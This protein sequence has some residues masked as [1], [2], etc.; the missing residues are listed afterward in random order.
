MQKQMMDTM[1]GKDPH[2]DYNVQ[3]KKMEWLKTY[4][5]TQSQKAVWDEAIQRH[6]KSLL[7]LQNE[8]KFFES[9]QNTALT[10]YDNYVDDVKN[11]K[12]RLISETNKFVLLQMKQNESRKRQEREVRLKER[13]DLGKFLPSESDQHLIKVAKADVATRR[14]LEE[15]HLS[16][17]QLRNDRKVGERLN[18]KTVAQKYEQEDIQ[19][20]NTDTEERLKRKRVAQQMSANVWKQQIEL[21]KMQRS[22]Q[23]LT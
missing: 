8:K 6:R 23:K 17:V 16:A 14:D 3:K 13:Y 4:K 18:E 7:S 10:S 11:S 15:S 20:L 22:L 9:E 2:D 12:Q 5:P 1:Y 19:K 21:K